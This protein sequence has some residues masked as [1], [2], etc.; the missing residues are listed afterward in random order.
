MKQTRNSYTSEDFYK[1]Y[2]DYTYG[3]E[4]CS[5]SRSVFLSIIRD[6]FKHIASKVIEQSKEVTLPA[7]LGSLYVIK[8]KPKKISWNNMNV[9]FDATKEVGKAVFHLNE[10]S[11]G[12]SFRFHWKKSDIIVKNKHMYELIMTR[13]NKRMLAYMIKEKRQDYIERN[14]DI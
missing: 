4:A 11:N 12:Y 3:N 6:Y 2:V 8:R 7:R 5:V 10:H 1:S 14:Y 9:D 13:A